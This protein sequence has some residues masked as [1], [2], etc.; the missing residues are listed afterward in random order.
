MPHVIDNLSNAVELVYWSEI[1]SDPAAVA[2]IAPDIQV[3]VSGGH[4][5]ISPEFQD[6]F[7]ALKIVS[8]FGVGYDHIDA[9]H[10]ASRGVMVTNTPDVLSDEVADTAM[11]LLLMTVRELGASERYLRA[12]R[13]QSEGEYPLS[14]TLRG[15]TLGIF[16]LGRIGKA[17]AHRGEAFGLDI[18][19]HGRRKQ[20]DMAYPYY[21]SLVGM[22]EACDILL[23]V[24]PGGDLTKNAVN[25]DVL[26][27][28]GA[29]GVLI[30]VGRGSS[31]DEDALSAALESGEIMGAGLDVFASEPSVPAALMDFDRVTLLP[32]VGSASVETRRAMA[33]LV[34]DNVL[35]WIDD[36]PVISPVAECA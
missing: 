19:Y 18:I 24:V 34:V 36:K 33:Q 31:V 9:A 13:W 30:N 1:S 29:N 12:G 17:I 27:A 28:L 6:Q 22:A 25:A 32:H 11:G 21:D 35:R 26:S 5:K 16:G 7:P 2:R 4:I 3:I 14:S 23:A 10:A 20:G 15:R 8:S